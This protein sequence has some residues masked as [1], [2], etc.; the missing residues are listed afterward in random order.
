MNKYIVKYQIEL[1]DGYAENTNEITA[2]SMDAAE[3]YCLRILRGI[4]PN[5]PIRVV[6]VLEAGEPSINAYY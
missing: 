3:R 2:S 4:F 1:E 5:L 6:S